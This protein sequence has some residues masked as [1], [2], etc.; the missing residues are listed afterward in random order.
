MIKQYIKIAFIIYILCA[1]FFLMIEKYMHIFIFSQLFI[2]SIPLIY[3]YVF[4]NPEENIKPED[5][6][7]A[8]DMMFMLSALGIAFILV[9]LSFKVGWVLLDYVFKDK[10]RQAFCGVFQQEFSIGQGKNKRTYWTIENLKTQQTINFPYN[11][12]FF[13]DFYRYGDKVCITYA[14]DERWLDVPYI[15]SFSKDFRDE[16]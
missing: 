11:R 16:P 8:I 12:H 5:R 15:Y 10:P 6:N 13:K 7:Q 4:L 2:A 14:F 3:L 9:V 1:I